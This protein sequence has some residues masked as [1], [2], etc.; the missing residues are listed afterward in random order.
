MGFQLW[1]LKG[2]AWRHLLAM[3]KFKKW[4]AI[5]MSRGLHSGNIQECWS[6]VQ[7]QNNIINAEIQCIKKNGTSHF[8]HK[9]IN[10]GILLFV[11]RFEIQTKLW[12][13]KIQKLLFVV[14]TSC[15]VRYL[16][17]V[18]GMELSHQTQKEMTCPSQGQIVPDGT[19]G[20]TCRQCT[21]CPTLQALSVLDRSKSANLCSNMA[22]I[23]KLSITSSFQ[24]YDISDRDLVF[25]N[26]M[27]GKI[28]YGQCQK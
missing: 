17:P 6:N 7:I 19:H 10:K 1:N 13:P 26:V 24:Q 25:K 12:E 11:S 22:I 28:Q 15:Q 2:S 27:F 3:Q 16:G 4:S 20:Q 21:C 8:Y 18:Q 14:L 9:I 23:L 5:H